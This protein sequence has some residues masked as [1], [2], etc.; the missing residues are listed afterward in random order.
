MKRFFLSLAAIASLAVSAVAQQTIFPT[1]Y[2]YEENRF[3]FFVVNDTG[4]NGYYD[5]DVVAETMGRLSES[6]NPEFIAA[7]GDTHHFM[8]VASVNDPLW[9]TNYE[10][11]YTH[12]ELMIPWYAVCG[13]HEYRGNT[14]AI[15]D[16]SKVSRRWHCPAK[17]YTKRFEEAGRSVLVVFIDTPPLIDKY[18]KDTEKYPDAVKEDMGAQLQWIDKVLKESKDTWKIVVGHHPIYA[19]TSKSLAERTNMQERVDPILRK[20][21]VDI[22]VCGHIHNFQHIRKEGTDMD[23]VVNSA[24]ALC[25]PAKPIEGTQFFSDAAGF[26]VISIDQKSLLMHFVDKN[27]NFIYTI[28]REK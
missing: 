28:Q 20:Y 19:D 1:P 27:G 13:N 24:G 15:I 18:R 25:R 8:G 17:Y 22:Y 4:R 11:I 9:M 6:M 2:D 23:Y 10:L 7:A 26:S 14:Q 12:P 5:Q 3:N 21:G 16:Y